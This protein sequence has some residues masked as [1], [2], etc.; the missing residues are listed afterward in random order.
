LALEELLA[1]TKPLG[2]NE[3]FHAGAKKYKVRIPRRDSH[4]LPMPLDT[5]QKALAYLYCAPVEVV[6]E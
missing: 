3:V 5:I 1:P 4:R 2:V 6:F